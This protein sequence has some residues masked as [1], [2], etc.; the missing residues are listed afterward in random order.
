MIIQLT[1]TAGS[2][3]AAAE[4]KVTGLLNEKRHFSI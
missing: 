2:D 1:D 4:N 3:E